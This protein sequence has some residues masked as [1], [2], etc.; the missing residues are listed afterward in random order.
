MYR[1]RGRKKGQKED[2]EK[3][4]YP[5]YRISIF[6][7]SRV[8]K[9]ELIHR[10]LTDEPVRQN[11]FDKKKHHNNNKQVEQFAFK[12][13]IPTVEDYYEFRFQRGNITINLELVDTSGGEQFPAM[14]R[15]NIQRSALV[16]IMYDVSR[17]STVKEAIRLY[18]FTRD[19]RPIESG[20]MIIFLGGK[21][22]LIS[23]EPGDGRFQNKLIKA[24]IRKDDFNVRS[25]VCS[26]KTGYNIRDLFEI[27]LE[28]ELEKIQCRQSLTFM[29]SLG[30]F[31]KKH[32]GDSIVD[33]HSA[34]YSQQTKKEK[35][36]VQFHFPHRSKQ[37]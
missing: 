33:E 2:Q 17:V 13:Y 20:Q 26:A 7:D 34:N 31:N 25:L 8:G 5:S 35:K 12:P 3:V 18:E 23:S 4:S 22:D 21:S 1:F 37:E 6:G 28:Q 24:G 32:S 27:G 19:T 10:F 36:K 11:M 29:N 15:L 30:N 16:I 9:S 14:R